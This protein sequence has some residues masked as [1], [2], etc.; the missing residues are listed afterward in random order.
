MLQLFQ[1]Q[2]NGTSVTCI[3]LD[4]QNPAQQQVVAVAIIGATVAAILPAVQAARE[5][6]TRAQ[7]APSPGALPEGSVAPGSPEPGQRR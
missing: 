1:P 6:A 4:G 5:A 2:R 3:H 7:A